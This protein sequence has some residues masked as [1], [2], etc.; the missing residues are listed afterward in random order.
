MQI[1]KLTTV[2]K[3]PTQKTVS[4]EPERVSKTHFATRPLI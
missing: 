2:I 1:A 3:Q 4:P